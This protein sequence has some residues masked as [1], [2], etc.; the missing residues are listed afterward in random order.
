MDQ[1][2][3]GSPPGNSRVDIQSASPEAD[4]P[5]TGMS[6]GT[7]AALVVAT[8]IVLA[9][10]LAAGYGLLTHPDLTA[11]LRDISIIVLAFV[12]VVIGLF[13]IV[14][15]FQLQSLIALLR[16]EVGPILESANQTAGTVRGTTAFV[17]DAVVTPMINVAS[18]A[19]G[20]RHTIKVLTGGGN[21]SKRRTSSST[22]S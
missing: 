14:L 3:E 1:V 20:V 11:G 19:S 2:E 21:R 12:S 9:V 6:R 22:D 15:I 18:Y 4:S 17:S 5:S 7:M 13:L 8:V 10:L 16:D